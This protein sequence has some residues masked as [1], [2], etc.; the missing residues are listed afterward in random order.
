MPSINTRR[1]HLEEANRRRA[2]RERAGS[3]GSRRGQFI[4]FMKRQGVPEEVREAQLH[5]FDEMV[6]TMEEQAEEQAVD[7][8]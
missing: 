6:E 3:L 2:L 1:R 8:L 5:K 7:G 4:E